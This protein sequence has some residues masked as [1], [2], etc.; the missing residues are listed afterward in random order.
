MLLSS[1]GRFQVFDRALVPTL[2]EKMHTGDKIF[3]MF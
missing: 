1:G 3:S 2:Q